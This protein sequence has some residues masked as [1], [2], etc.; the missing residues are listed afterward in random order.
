MLLSQVEAFLSVA[1]RRSVSAAAEVLYVT[2]P[3]LTTRIKNLEREL[4]VQL[5]VRT[6]RGMRLTAEGRA[7]RPHA[8]RALQELAEG[9]ELLRERR[10]GRVGELLVGAAPAIST[11]VLP[12][13]LRRFQASFPNVHLIVRTGHSEEVLEQVLRE[14]VQVGLVR[15]LPHPAVLSTPLYEDEIVLVVHPAHRFADAEAIV[16]R[17]L[18]AE[19]LIL[20]DRT[21]S[22]FVLTSAFFREAGIVPRGVMELDNVDATKKMVE[23][24]LGIAFLPYTAVRGELAAGALQEVAIEGYEPVRRMIVAIRRRDAVLPTDLIDGLLGAVSRDELER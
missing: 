20:F 2:Q 21:S 22:Y 15:E 12:L 5:F 4:G 3:A 18:A 10:E 13:V 6:P 17:E 1:E 7:F 24:G 14:Q 16:V 8:Q 9:R 23:H 11:Y 19:R